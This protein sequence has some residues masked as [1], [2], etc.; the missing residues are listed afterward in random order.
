MSGSPRGPSAHQD[1]RQ[2]R[3]GQVGRRNKCA[4]R[5]SFQPV[6]TDRPA[7]SERLCEA[8]VSLPA[9]RVL[10]VIMR[11]II[12]APIT[13]VLTFGRLMRM[14]TKFM[15]A[16]IVGRSTL[17]LPRAVGCVTQARSALFIASSRAISLNGF[18]KHATAPCSRTRERMA[19][20]V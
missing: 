11:G 17:W 19:S 2:E 20:S 9:G 15:S 12:A 16:N 13:A 1:F 18:N 7:R 10:P 8:V 5:H 3:G 6:G 4:E 14:P